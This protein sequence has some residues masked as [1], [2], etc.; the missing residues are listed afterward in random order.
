MPRDNFLY[1]RVLLRILKEGGEAPDL[2]G[3]AAV[4]FRASETG[5][6]GAL[7]KPDVFLSGVESGDPVDE[8]IQAA[9]VGYVRVSP[10]EHPCRSAWAVTEITGEGYGRLV[11]GMGYALSP[12]NML[13]SDRTSV[14]APAYDSWASAFQRAGKGQKLPLDDHENPKTPSEDDDCVI[15]GSWLDADCSGRDPKPLNYA[16]RGGSWTRPMLAE[17]E[18]AHRETLTRLSRFPGGAESIRDIDSKFLAAGRRLF[19]RTYPM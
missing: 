4:T 14:S 9:V 18:A 1:E 16:Y 10:T 12:R 5:R 15:H 7:Y 11:Y 17:L 3:L 6:T 8:A 2:E 13:V 19:K